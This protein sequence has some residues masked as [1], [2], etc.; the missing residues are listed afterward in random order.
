MKKNRLF[1]LVAILLAMQ[2]SAR[3]ISSRSIFDFDKGLD[4]QPSFDLIVN[5]KFESVWS[6]PCLSIVPM[7]YFDLNDWSRFNLGMQIKLSSPRSI[8]DGNTSRV[9]SNKAWYFG[10]A[11]VVSFNLA[12]FFD[13]GLKAYAYEKFYNAKN[14]ENIKSTLPLLVVHGGIKHKFSNDINFGL[15]LEYGSKKNTTNDA[16]TPLMRSVGYFLLGYTF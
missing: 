6:A 1:V 14:L 9:D 15:G 11:P 5:D 3:D 16:S 10:V 7:S 12:N 4:F 8:A 2:T 13:V